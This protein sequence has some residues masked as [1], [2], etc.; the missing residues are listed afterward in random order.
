M[1][2][3][4]HHPEGNRK[5]LEWFYAW[6]WG[7]GWGRANVQMCV[8]AKTTLAPVCVLGWLLLV[9]VL[10]G[11]P[12]VKRDEVEKP[13]GRGTVA[14]AQRGEGGDTGLGDKIRS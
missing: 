14:G 6:G 10:V 13:A 1:K 12:L 3:P 5:Q 9:V 11:R 8:F 2:G 7:V 4:R